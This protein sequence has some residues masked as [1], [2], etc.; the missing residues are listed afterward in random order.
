MTV[1]SWP[2]HS[3]RS[4]IR[5]QSIHEVYAE[6]LDDIRACAARDGYIV[7]ATDTWNEY[8][9]FDAPIVHINYEIAPKGRKDD[10]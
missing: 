3:Q 1:K 4:L 8:S 10:L 5:G 2:F 6:I 9:D 7:S